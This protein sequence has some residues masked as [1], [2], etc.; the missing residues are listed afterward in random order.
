LL[1]GA[2]PAGR[3]LGASSSP[4]AS[5]AAA[6]GT[7]AAQGIEA[8][9]VA[10]DRSNYSGRAQRIWELREYPASLVAFFEA[11]L[12]RSTPSRPT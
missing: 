4:S 9:G 11:L 12:A 1:S 3:S 2:P 6:S 5:T 10:A 8:S 7:C